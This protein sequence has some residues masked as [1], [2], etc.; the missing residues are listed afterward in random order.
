MEEKVLYRLVL[1]KPCDLLSVHSS[2]LAKGESYQHSFVFTNKADADN[3]AND[4]ITQ[5]KA[6]W[7]NTKNQR[8]NFVNSAT[9]HWVTIGNPQIDLHI[10]SGVIKDLSH[11]NTQKCNY[12]LDQNLAQGLLNVIHAIIDSYKASGK[13][14]AM[15][16]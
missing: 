5:V 4:I 9:Y 1:S 2:I 14:T 12:F 8:G 6:F 16:V 15:D 3:M 7:L 10:R 11:T 13:L